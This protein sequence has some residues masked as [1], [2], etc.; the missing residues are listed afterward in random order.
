ML[1][2]LGFWHL[3][4]AVMGFMG[5]VHTLTSL[6]SARG[7]LVDGELGEELR[8]GVDLLPHLSIGISN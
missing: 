2:M 7:R 8:I 3:A 5:I 1:I 4:P 6:S